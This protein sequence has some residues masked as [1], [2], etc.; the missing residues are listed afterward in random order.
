LG[1]LLLAAY[2]AGDAALAWGNRTISFAA[3]RAGLQALVPA[4]GGIA[5]E[6]TWW[7]AFPDRRYTTDDFLY[8]GE[9]DGGE[10]PTGWLKQVFA[11]R[12]IRIVLQDEALSAFPRP[13]FVGDQARRQ[14]AFD[15]LLR[16]EC[17]PLGAV[18]ADFY[19]IDHGA[20]MRRRTVVW[21]CPEFAQ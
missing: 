8:E 3:Y 13:S 12:E 18:E 5:G 17:K 4:Q 21:A 20:L 15:A 14:A 10:D 2:A 6:G 19:G 9:R 16:E 1:G 11:E 7:F